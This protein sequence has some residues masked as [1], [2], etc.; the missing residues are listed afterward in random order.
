MLLIRP[1]NNE[2]SERGSSV[3]SP[4]FP[5]SCIMRRSLRA[6]VLRQRQRTRIDENPVLL[7]VTTN[8]RCKNRER[9]VG[10]PAGADFRLVKVLKH[11]NTR[12]SLR[13]TIE[14]F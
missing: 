11:V 13:N 4:H 1:L 9:D 6:S 5:V 12:P 8:Y 7:R 2:G 10:L 14:R 3:Q